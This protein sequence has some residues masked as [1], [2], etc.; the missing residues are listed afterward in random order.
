ML[1]RSIET[2]E[3]KWNV[4]LVF[5]GNDKEHAFNADVCNI[6]KELSNNLF[7]L[8]SYSIT[9][10]QFDS[11]KNKSFNTCEGCRIILKLN[12]MNSGTHTKDTMDISLSRIFKEGP[13]VS[14]QGSPTVS[15]TT[16][17]A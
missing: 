14:L 16:A 17:A 3:N 9:K 13:E 7:D 5:Y 4:K 2:N 8:E 12:Y 1:F 10:E 6:L 11:M 15:P